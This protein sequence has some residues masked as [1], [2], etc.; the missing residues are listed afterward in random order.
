MTVNAME[1][2]EDIFEMAKL[3]LKWKILGLPRKK[4]TCSKLNTTNL[5][6]R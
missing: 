6:I 2:W 3:Q 1:R 4:K 5:P